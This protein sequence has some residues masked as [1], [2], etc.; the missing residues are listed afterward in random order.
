MLSGLC[1]PG[2]GTFIHSSAI[3]GGE[4]R[5]PRNQTNIFPAGTF[6]GIFAPEKGSP[7]LPG[8]PPGAAGE[9]TLFA[10]VSHVGANTACGHYVCHVRKDG[11]WVI[12][13]DSKARWLCPP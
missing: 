5:A 13:N 9:Y 10:V 12:Y 8:P 11:R 1:Q 2:R 3:R 4:P 6:A 7:F